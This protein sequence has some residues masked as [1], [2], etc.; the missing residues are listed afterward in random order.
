M[1]DINVLKTV[2]V[3]YVED[4]FILRKNIAI[5]LQRRCKEV[6]EAENG[7]VGLELYNK[8]RVDIV[9]TDLEMPVM[10]GFQMITKILEIKDTQPI[11]ITTGYSDE[12]QNIDGVCDHMIKPLDEDQLIKAILL[13][14]GNRV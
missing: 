3:L 1:E 13:C 8:H 4:N 7:K 12:E 10:N 11:I 9:I 14:L 2:N 5:F 6:Y